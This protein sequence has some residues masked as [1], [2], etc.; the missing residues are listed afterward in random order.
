MDREVTY[1]LARL[2]SIQWAW[3]FYQV[4]YLGESDRQEWPL[5]GELQVQSK[6]VVEASFLIIEEEQIS[7]AERVW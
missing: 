5:L 3:L 6:E 7:V 4:G 2:G 1:V